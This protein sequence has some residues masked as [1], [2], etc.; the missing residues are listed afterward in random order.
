VTEHRKEKKNDELY[1]LKMYM[2]RKTI[3]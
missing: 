1:R 3:H 2:L